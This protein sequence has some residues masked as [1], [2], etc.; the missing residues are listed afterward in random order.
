MICIHGYWFQS[1][2]EKLVSC[3]LKSLGLRNLVTE[4]NNKS[5][6]YLTY[7]S[8]EQSLLQWNTVL[9]IIS[10]AV[11]DQS[12]NR[13]FLYQV[14]LHPLDQ[15]LMIRVDPVH[16]SGPHSLLTYI[17][18]SSGKS[19]LCLLYFLINFTHLV[20]VCSMLVLAVNENRE[21]YHTD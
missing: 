6:S 9:Q 8:L 2:V 20:N 1:G 5:R 10:M 12:V 4:K 16:M 21:V 17:M 18:C 11:L 15:M 3:R 14:R 13:L 19:S 7:L